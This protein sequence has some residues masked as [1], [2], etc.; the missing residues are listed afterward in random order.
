MVPGQPLLGAILLQDGSVSAP[1]LDAALSYQREHHCRLGEALLA[2]D[3]C[4]DVQLARALAVQFDMPFVDLVAT[5]PEPA[6]HLFVPGDVARK[7]G[8]VP[9]RR[10]DGRLLVV[11]RN[12]FDFNV[13]VALRA[14]ARMPVRVACG[15]ESQIAEALRYYDR[16]WESPARRAADAH[17]ACRGPR[18]AAQAPTGGPELTGPNEEL[19]RRLERGACRVQL[20]FER[21]TVCVRTFDGARTSR[22]T[23]LPARNLSITIE[24]PAADAPRQESGFCRVSLRRR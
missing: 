4:T 13:D 2:L 19:R 14:A 16:P 7:L 23:E 1:Q 10:E 9:V 17:T 22:V 11:A 15:V 3:Y 8:S 24:P 6:A 20:E 12:P 21:D 18:Y 5:P